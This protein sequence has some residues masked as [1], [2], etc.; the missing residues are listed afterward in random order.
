MV[1]PFLFFFLFYLHPIFFLFCLICLILLPFIL[2]FSF[3]LY[4]IIHLNYILSLWLFLGREET[5]LLCLKT[6]L[7]G[8]K[9]CICTIVL[10]DLSPVDQ[11]PPTRN[12]RLKTL[13]RH[14]YS[15]A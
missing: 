11:K 9:I 10:L 15:I 6:Q 8:T 13:Y 3:K 12:K 1:G 2:S 7:V 14:M 5:K 4:Y